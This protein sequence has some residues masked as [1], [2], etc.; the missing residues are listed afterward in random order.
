ME[1]VLLGGL[2][3]LAPTQVGLPLLLFAA[4]AAIAV[5]SGVGVVAFN[6]PV[7]SALC[8]VA[9]FLSL[10]V[11]Y[12]TLGAEML[13]IVQVIVYTGAI[14]VLFLFVLMLLNLGAPGALRESRDLRRLA[15]GALAGALFLMVLV[16]RILGM[17]FFDPRGPVWFEVDKWVGGGNPLLFQ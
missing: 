4:L 1:G 17:G 14:M 9:N 2:A 6:N 11:L 12:F 5:A 3:Q 8:L 10:A 7:R 13:G 16:Q 15:A